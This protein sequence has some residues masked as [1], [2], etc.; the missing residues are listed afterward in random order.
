MATGA[1]A[2]EVDPSPQTRSASASNESIEERC[3]AAAL[4]CL[5]AHY[6]NSPPMGPQ[7]NAKVVAMVS[8]TLEKTH[9]SKEVR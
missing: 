1:V 2:D 3:F 5:E 4:I 7:T 8:R 6:D 9:A